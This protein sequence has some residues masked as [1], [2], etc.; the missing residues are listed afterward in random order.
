MNSFL[1]TIRGVHSD[2]VQYGYVLGYEPEIN[3]VRR[4]GTVYWTLAVRG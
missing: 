2:S 3:Y 4:V 1:E